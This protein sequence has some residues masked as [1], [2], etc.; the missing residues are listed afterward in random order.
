MLNTFK[1]FVIK[2]VFSFAIGVFYAG[3]ATG[4]YFGTEKCFGSKYA[5]NAYSLHTAYKVK[6]NFKEKRSEIGY[7][8]LSS[9]ATVLDDVLY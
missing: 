4:Y 5:I 6:A 3:Y 9:H 2:N 8:N 1:I 7:T